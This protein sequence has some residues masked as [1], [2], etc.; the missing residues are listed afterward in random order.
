MRKMTFI[1]LSILIFVLS[2]APITSFALDLGGLD[3][4]LVW[5]VD[6]FKDNGDGTVTDT[7]NG[8]IWLK[9]G[10][11]FEKT[12]SWQDATDQVKTL[13]HGKCGLKDNSAAGDWRLPTSSELQDLLDFRAF[14]PDAPSEQIFSNVQAYY[15]WSSDKD[16]DRT[17][18]QP[19]GWSVYVYG[20]P[21][22][23]NL[24]SEL[25]VWPARGGK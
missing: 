12:L 21:Y 6:R 20:T 19:C 22:S 25:N 3:E 13:A 4:E 5:P 7:Q 10:N 24:T 1:L 15:Y 16:V 23:S 9:N 8:V 11:C 18:G 14:D 2:I 17:E